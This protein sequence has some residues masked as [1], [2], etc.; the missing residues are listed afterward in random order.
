MEG[1]A[2]EAASLAGHLQARQ[3]DLPV[4]RQPRHA[5]R[6]HRH[7]VLGRS[8]ATFRGL[9]L[10]H[11][12]A[13]TTAT[14]SLRSTRR[15]Q[16]R[17]PKRARPSLILVRTHIGYGSPA[18][19]TASRRTVRRSAWRKCSKTKQNAGLAD[20]AAIS[21]AGAG[22][23]AFSRSDR[24]AAREPKPSG[25]AALRRVCDE[26][27]PNS[28]RNCNAAA[29]RA[30]PT[31]G[32]R[33][34]R[35]FPADAKGMA[36]RVASG[37]VMNAIAPQLAGADRRLGRSGSVDHT[38]LQGLGDFDPAGDGAGDD[39]QGST[40]GGWSYAGR[41]LHFGVREHAMGAIA[42]RTGGARRHSFR[43]ARRS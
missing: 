32:T 43:S 4:R 22:A 24:R 39:R 8:R 34:S 19:R 18:S 37:K 40:G 3:A 29:R 16:R 31:A 20:R 10:A 2:S 33:T 13:S 7:H 15:L 5:F 42:E 12:I 30:C 17:A 25:T 21:H 6:R 1:V 41:N 11:L 38:A 35:I 23:G 27:F 36:T 14:I 28:P 9:W 26:R